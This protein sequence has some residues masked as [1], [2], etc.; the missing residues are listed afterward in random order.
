[1]LQGMFDGLYPPGYQWYWKADFVKELGHE[2]IALHCK[3]GAELPTLHSTMHLY[4]I[5]GAA[6]KRSNAAVFRLAF[7]L[8]LGSG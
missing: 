7:R 1:M 4:P 2:A 5:N 3:H 8:P 6:Q